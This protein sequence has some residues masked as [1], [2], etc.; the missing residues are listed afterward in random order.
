MVDARLAMFRRTCELI[1]ADRRHCGRDACRH[2]ELLGQV[3][4]CALLIQGLQ[5]VGRILSGK[6]W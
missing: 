3:D 5:K 1:A 6:L 4:A 2:Q